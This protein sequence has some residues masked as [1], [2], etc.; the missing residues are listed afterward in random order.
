MSKGR[1]PR[2]FFF[3]MIDVHLYGKCELRQ[4]GVRPEF[5]A[6]LCDMLALGASS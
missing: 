5:V 2:P 6:Q 3:A 1:H 4:S